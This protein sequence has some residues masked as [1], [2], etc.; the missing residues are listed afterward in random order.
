MRRPNG[1]GTIVKLS[2]QRRRPYAVRISVT[3]PRGGTIIQKALSYHGTLS[4]AQR[5][6]DS[7]NAAK[8][9]GTAPAADKLDWTVLQ[10]Y[11]GWSGRTYKKLNPPSIASHKAAWNKRVSRYADRKMRDVTLDEWQSILDEDEDLGLS[12]S[13]INND[14]ALIRGL[15]A[16]SMERDIIGKDY[17]R[18]LDIPSV[19][20]KHR[21][22]ALNDLQMDKLE[23]MAA[24]GFPW[25]DTA[26]IMC[27]TGLRISELLGL[28]RFSYHTEDGG[29][30]KCGIKTAAGKERVIPV[31]AKIVPYI[32]R[33]LAEEGDAIILRDGHPVL[34]NWYRINAFPPIVESLGIPE[35][36]PH[37]CRHTF[38]TRLHAAGVDKLEMKWLLG[39]S[40]KG[41]TTD[42]YTHK[43][44]D[45]LRSAIKKLA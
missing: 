24:A 28:T 21:K 40:T 10:V 37:W 33:G 23:K 3:G 16:Y 30:L 35:A 38:A 5:A 34:P 26:L 44:M 29:Y 11:E 13:T 4:E 15:Y 2:G 9:S 32:M 8:A 45:L 36:T 42:G 22:G 41:D 27:Y 7:Y 39:H 14:A 31:H 25:A 1:T 43:S 19:D 6:L 20:P 18:Y 12:Q 17:S